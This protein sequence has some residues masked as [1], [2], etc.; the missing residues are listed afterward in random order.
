[1]KLPIINAQDAAAGLETLKKYY[2]GNM[3]PAE[4]KTYLTKLKDSV[5]P[6]M[7][8]ESSSG[9]THYLLDAASQIATLGHGFNPSVFFG[10]AQ[11]LE[12]WINDS[13]T[14]E[15]K[16][17]RQAFVN[18]LGR[19]LNWSKTFITTTHSGAEANEVAL[20]YC[21]QKRVN[22]TANKVLAFEGSFHGRMMVTLA[23][24][25][26]KSKREP[27]EWKNYLAE[28]VKYPELDDSKINVKF[29]KDWRETWNEA[30]LKNFKVPTSWSED[31][32]I[33]KEVDVLLSVRE[34]L[35]SKNIFAVLIEPMQCE[36]GD[37]Y[38]SDR[39]HTA[40]LL[41]AKT[42]KVPVI[43]DEVQ[44]GF[45]LGREFFWHRQLKMKGL[46]GEQLNPDYVVCA[47]KSQVGL[48]LSHHE[49]KK[50]FY[51]EEF[52]VAS[53]FRGY[54]HAISLDQCQSRI[55]D[56]ESQ[57]GPRVE[58]LIKK[59]PE[60]IRRPRINGMA[61][62][63]DVIDPGLL[64]KFVD[65][66]FKHGLLYYPAGSQTL[67]FR[68]NTAFGTKD[69]DF[70]FDRLD[71]IC[72]E[73]FLKVELP[74]PTHAETDNLGSAE[75]YQWHELMLKTKLAKVFG[76][77]IE[78]TAVFES[79]NQLLNKSVEALQVELIE[80]NA[81]NF[82]E[83]R[84]SIINLQKNVYEPARQTDIEKFE[85]T[86]LDKNAICLGLV[87]RKK[88]LMAIAFA[89]P[90]GLYPLER[91]V[92]MDPHFKDHDSLY[93]LDVTIDPSLQKTGLGR[94][95]KYALS[96]MAIIK[97]I[98]RIQGRNRDRL[99][100]AMININLSLGAIEQ[101][102]MLE[103]YPDFEDHRDV[104]Y[105]TTK[106][107]WKKPT[108]H[109]SRGTT[110]PLSIESLNHD[111]FDLQLPYLINKVCLSNF[112]SE[113]FL[114]GVK[115]FLTVLPEDLRHG[116][117]TSGQSEAT[118]KVA[119]AIWVKSEAS[120]R[121]KN[122]NKMLTFTNHFFGNGSMLA[123][124][125]SYTQDGYFNS[126][127]LPHPNVNNYQEVLS[128]VEAEMKKEEYLAVWIEPVLQ[129]TMEKVP[130]DFLIELRKLASRYNVALVYNETAS[131]FYRYSEKSFLASALPGISP[132]AGLIYMSGQSGLA[133]TSTKY[134]LEQPLMMISTWDGDEFHFLSYYESFKNV[135]K[136]SDE[137]KKT[138]KAFHAK[139][140]DKLSTYDMDVIKIE[141]GFGYFKG[142]I[143]NSISKMFIQHCGLYI[144]CPSFDAMK[145]YLKS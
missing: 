41:M 142:S 114:S 135:I 73:L 125:L 25:W 136:N 145:E 85:H 115:D 65:L 76:K 10:S 40:L 43:H 123:R 101:N 46:S 80:I 119:K 14:K 126:T 62:A 77:K 32:M 24:T 63:F 103:D 117:T 68:L 67:R 133:F 137:Y 140:I 106:V 112:V 66:R 107:D 60:F 34:Q 79:I 47:K 54:A 75:I 11:F 95:L 50:I 38:S 130:M 13:T 8:I 49:T 69:F 108:I 48:V 3:I 97:G 1:M 122:I 129:K 111:Y 23:A 124:S 91:G 55:W 18:F 2:A 53:F 17:A 86:V 27:F 45:H 94:N 6:Y 96:T 72:S 116:Y 104:F 74:L 64:N 57:V 81:S 16:E 51:G 15:F 28:Y 82:L 21:Y 22:P 56:L 35:L 52:S 90:L 88:K 138:A 127:K 71:A 39:F 19:K 132:D 141:N 29:P 7:A 87:N 120:L 4:K 99:A 83:F 59:Y 109:L 9:E 100:G 70:L 5:G 78:A 84:D 118:D 93:M 58:A 26:N 131:Q 37:C 12:S 36:G 42:F 98:K 143:P 33:K 102:Y 128:L 121:E 105:Y 139:L 30:S 92:R 44:T 134:F 113:A 144:V 110:I 61:F 20:G 31:L 89:G